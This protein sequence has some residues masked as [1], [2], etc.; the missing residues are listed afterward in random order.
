MSSDNQTQSGSAINQTSDD[1]ETIPNPER[2]CGYLKEG[3]AYLRAD[4]SPLGTLP[5][6][7][8]FE[9]PI[10]FKED[11]KR[12]Y[13]QFPGIQFELSVTGENGLTKT[14]PEGEV[15]EHINRL[16]SDL[17]TGRTAGEMVSFESHDLL[18]SVGKTH[19]ETPEQFIN[20]A[21]V[22]GVNKAISVTS[23]NEPPKVN[24]GRTRLFLIHPR[25]CE[26]TTTEM[27]EQEVT[28]K[29]KV[30]LP[31]GDTKTVAYKDTERVEVEKI[32]YV[33]GIIGYTYMTRVVY[34]EDADGN[35]PKYIQDYESTGD[36]D[37]VQIGEEVPFS[38]QEDFTEDGEYAPTFESTPAIT[39]VDGDAERVDRAA[40]RLREART[41][42]ED[43]E[44]EAEAPAVDGDP[45]DLERASL[46][47]LAETDT[48]VGFAPADEYDAM[49]DADDGVLA[50]V[51]G[52]EGEPQAVRPGASVSVESGPLYDYATTVA[53]PYR[54]TV[55][56]DGE[57][58]Y[59]VVERT[60]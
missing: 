27:E 38:E 24:P 36:L 57:N 45:A 28:K 16:T 47:V 13:K 8:E 22:H 48:T 52:E 3:K 32:E 23:G 2:G 15:F 17:P 11:R 60:R 21:R 46:S 35:V 5:A 7:V 29:E 53:G 1:M 10:P 34:T 20:E 40:Q 49:Q 37:V 44:T 33:P 51:Y 26:F 30:A 31:N 59:V 42:M 19:Y 4:L 14:D 43:S 54:V 55:T 12:S 41:V 50:I 9:T 58:R 18:M 39:R 25:A 56:A 6:F